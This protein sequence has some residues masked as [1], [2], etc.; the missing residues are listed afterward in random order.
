MPSRI[1]KI[2]GEGGQTVKKDEALMIISSM[3]MENTILAENEGT[4]TEVYAL[5]GQSVEAG[6]LLLK[7]E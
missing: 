6:F 3:K 5:E 4:V 2:L 7:V 1:I